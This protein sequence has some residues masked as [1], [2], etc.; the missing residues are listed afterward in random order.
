MCVCSKIACPKSV[1]ALHLRLNK[2]EN[3]ARGSSEGLVK[4][5]GGK[6]EGATG[7]KDTGMFG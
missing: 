7:G 1:T 6:R 2:E 5:A 4:E 3:E